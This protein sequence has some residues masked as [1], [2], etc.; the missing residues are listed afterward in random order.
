[1]KQYRL[2]VL[3]ALAVVAATTVGAGAPAGAV[4]AV[5]AR[6]KVVFYTTDTQNLARALGANPSDCADYYIS[7]SP[8]TAA[9]AAGEPRGGAALTVVHAQGSSFHALAELQPKQWAAYA[10]ANGGWYATGVKLHDDMLAAGYDPAR[11]DT[12][13]VNEVGAPSDSPVSTNVLDGANGGRDNFREFVRGLYTGSAG[14]PLPGLVF[15]ADEPQL[16]PAVADYA[17]RLA[18]WYADAPFWE[19]MQRYVTTWAQETYAD[20]RAW[21]VAGS[22]LAEQTDS[23]NDYFLHGLRVAEEGNDEL[24]ASPAGVHGWCHASN[25]NETRGASRAVTRR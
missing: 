24:P 10:A 13:A 14:P 1:M 6:A 12:W 19:D 16:S 2:V 3:A 5:C 8:I 4:D 20:A 21:A 18:S 17:Q 25:A 9:P 7:I 11:G 15:A 22:P 23:L